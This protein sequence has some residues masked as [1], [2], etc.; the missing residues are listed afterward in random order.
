MSIQEE[1][2][3]KIV[4]NCKNIDKNCEIKIRTEFEKP[5]IINVMFTEKYR[6]IDGHDRNGTYYVYGDGHIDVY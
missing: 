1:N 5:T 2:V 4:E 3:K 6:Y